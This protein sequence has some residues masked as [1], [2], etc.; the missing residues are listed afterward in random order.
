[1]YP[2]PHVLSLVSQPQTFEALRQGYE[3][4]PLS[5]SRPGL[6]R[7]CSG[8]RGGQAMSFPRDSTDRTIVNQ[9]LEAA[10]NIGLAALLAGA[11]LL[12]LWPF[13]PLLSWGVI[14][15]VAAYPGFKKLQHMMG[16]H[17]VY[18]AIVF[19]VALLAVL[20]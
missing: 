4:K 6:M 11:C 15:A 20:I 8:F 10:I 16:G 17:S 7:Y 13:T 2:G 3:N 1:M 18:A 14:I 5:L 12:I 19:T 9:S